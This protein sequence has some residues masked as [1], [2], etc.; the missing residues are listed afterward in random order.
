MKLSNFINEILKGYLITFIEYSQNMDNFEKMPPTL[1]EHKL[2]VYHSGVFIKL[3][4]MFFTSQT[5]L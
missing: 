2:S 3:N 5:H 1:Y 4:N